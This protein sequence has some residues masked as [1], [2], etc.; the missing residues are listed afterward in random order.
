MFS[1]NFDVNLMSLGP[2]GQ[3]Y[4]GLL[5]YIIVLGPCGARLNRA[6]YTYYSVRALR[7]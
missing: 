1:F 7:G 5:T 4:T 3:D 6:P 2:A